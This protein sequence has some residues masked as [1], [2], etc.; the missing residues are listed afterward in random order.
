[1]RW[2]VVSPVVVCHVDAASWNLVI[3]RGRP[4][5]LID[6]DFTAPA[7]RV[8]DLASMARSLAPLHRREARHALGWPDDDEVGHRLRLFIDSYKP[9]PAERGALLEV[10]LARAESGN[11]H[12][13]N[14]L[15][16]G[17]PAWTAMARKGM[18]EANRA[19]AE[20]LRAMQERWARYL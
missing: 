6:W 3:Y 1:M 7:P 5:G 11:R 13:R 19:D 12:A 16:A 14:A 15:A 9:E 10:M 20:D 18:V 17:E 8:W 4:K 2:G